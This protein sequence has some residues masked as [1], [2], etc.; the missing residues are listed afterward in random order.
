V[1]NLGQAIGQGLSLGLLGL[2]GYMAAGESRPET[3]LWLRIFYCLVP[4]FIIAIPI[5]LLWRYPLTRERHRRFQA[6]VEHG[7]SPRGLAA[8]RATELS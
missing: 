5:F 1:V 6:R 7:F 3:L 4:S 2:V 8:Q